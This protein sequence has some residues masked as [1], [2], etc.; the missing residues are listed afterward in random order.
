MKTYITLIILGLALLF[1][2]IPTALAQTS[3]ASC[4][5]SG[6]VCAQVYST[7]WEFNTVK[8]ICYQPFAQCGG[9]QYPTQLDCEKACVPPSTILTP[10]IPSPTV[11]MVILPPVTIAPTVPLLSTTPTN[12]LTPPISITPVPTTP[13]PSI[14]PS[15]KPSDGDANNDGKT[16]L[17]DFEIFRQEVSGEVQSIRSDFNCD[18][19]VSIADFENFRRVF[20]GEISM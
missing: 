6:N 17:L 1:F 19:K 15:C 20:M 16:T 18:G 10:T 7:H 5:P 3:S 4:I 9:T 12:T 2:H 8:N 13:S 11:S 14:D